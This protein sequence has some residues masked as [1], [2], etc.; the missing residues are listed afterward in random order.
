[1][2]ENQSSIA[3]KIAAE[4]V[5]TAFLLAAIVGSGIMGERLSGGNVAIA[6][7]AN[8]ISTG[9]ALVALIL[10]FGPISGA[11]MNP[12]VTLAEALRTRHNADGLSW[13]S[14]AGYIAGQLTGAVAGVAAANVMFDV[15]VLIISRH[16]RSG[17]S[18]AFSEFVATFG[19]L[20]VI[21]C[22]AKS[23]PAIV[24]FAVGAYITSAYWFTASTSFA[25]PA[26]T[27]ARSLTNTFAGIRPADTPWFIAAQFAG[28]A[29]SLLFFGWLT[30][31][32]PAESTKE[33]LSHETNPDTLYRQ[34]R[35]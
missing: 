10:T 30:S 28:A 4:F 13:A 20:G 15:P 33:K 31:S 29:A 23:R 27:L 14:A 21:H 34:F 3:R 24:P 7:L 35:A 2:P 12:V 8:T 1:M 9:A 17:G 25:N 22:C 16:A 5:S 11:H 18:E 6:L 19:L 32:T 26:V